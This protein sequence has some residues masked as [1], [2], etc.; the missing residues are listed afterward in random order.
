MNGTNTNINNTDYSNTNFRAGKNGYGTF[1]N[2]FLTDDEYTDLKEK[3]KRYLDNYS[4]RLS[5]YIQSTGK[6]YKDHKATLLTWFYKD[7]GNN[8]QNNKSKNKS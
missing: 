6:E 1:Q 8:K 3:L 4:E 7:Q 2:V 5:N